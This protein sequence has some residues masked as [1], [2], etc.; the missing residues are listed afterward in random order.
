MDILVGI[1]LNLQ[2]ALGSIVILTIFF[3]SKI[4][5]YISMFLN[6]LPFP[7]SIFYRSQH[8]NL[9]PLL[10]RFIPKCFIYLLM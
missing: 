1:T 3:Q 9:L 10:V 4:L 2:I 5:G 7:L 6:H 8:T